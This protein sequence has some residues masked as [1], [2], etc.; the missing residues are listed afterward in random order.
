M[1]NQNQER[2]RTA[3]P[4]RA[5]PSQPVA[6][7][8]LSRTVLLNREQGRRA[9]PIRAHPSQPVA[10]RVLSRTVLLNREQGRRAPPIRAHPSQP[11]AIRVLSRTLDR[12]KE[13]KI[14]STVAT[15]GDPCSIAHH[16]PEQGTGKKG[17]PHPR[18]S[19]ATRGDPCSITHRAPAQNQEP[20]Q[21]SIYHTSG[22]LTVPQ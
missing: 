3:P 9:P 20:M 1:K 6:I 18:V 14:C 5:H 22:A 12:R 2:G 4:I 21:L 11:V 13:N 17:A 19:V 16:A 10:I 15:R 8:V 7:R